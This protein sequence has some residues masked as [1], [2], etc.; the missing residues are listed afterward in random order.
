MKP[1]G[2][3]ILVVAVPAGAATLVHCAWQLC[4][5]AFFLTQNV[6][7][8]ATCDPEETFCLCKSCTSCKPAVHVLTPV[9]CLL[10]ELN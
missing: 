10:L 5:V 2:C 9:T 7:Q 1:G 6:C 4:S 3:A 8:S